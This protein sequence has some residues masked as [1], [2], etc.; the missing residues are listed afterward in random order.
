MA[1]NTRV[2]VCIL[3]SFLDNIIELC[4]FP[5]QKPSLPFHYLQDKDQ[6]LSSVFEA[7]YHLPKALCWALPICNKSSSKTRLGILPEFTPYVLLRY[8]CISLSCPALSA[9]LCTP[10]T[11]PFS[12][13]WLIS[14]FFQEAFP[15]SPTHASHFFLY[16]YSRM[17][18]TISRYLS[19][20]APH[21]CAS[22]IDMTLPYQLL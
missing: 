8:F 2:N 19:Y 5:A 4:F 6:F 1:H 11:H 22:F 17:N 9:Y 7:H 12:K 13:H 16:S 20:P 15:C 14:F 10:N 18:H 3:A 21:S